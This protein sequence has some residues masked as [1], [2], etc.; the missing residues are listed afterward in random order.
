[1]RQKF[2]F[3]YL[4]LKNV[5]LIDHPKI[6]KIWNIQ[7]HLDVQIYLLIDYQFALILLFLS[8]KHKVHLIQ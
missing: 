6:R 1:M 4:E 3:I 7:H 2:L 8:L 5:K